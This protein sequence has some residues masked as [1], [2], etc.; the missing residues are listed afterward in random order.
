MALSKEAELRVRAIL[1]EDT[2]ADASVIEQILCRRGHEVVIAQNGRE[3]VEKC[4]RRRF[5]VILMDVQMPG[6]D[7]L[8]AAAA[9]RALA[10]PPNDSSTPPDV[11]II[12]VTAYAIEGVKDLCLEAGMNAFVPKPVDAEEVLHL[13]E[14][15]ART[16][17][18]TVFPSDDVR[19]HR[20]VSEPTRRTGLVHQESPPVPLVGE[21]ILDLQ[22]T[23]KRLGEDEALLDSLIAMFVDDAPA[24][25]ERIE[26]G[27]DDP[28]PSEPTRAAHSLKGLAANLSARIA[29]ASAAEVEKALA[30]RNRDEARR[31]LE[32]LRRRIDEV[33]AELRRRR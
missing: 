5:D 19:I 7:G 2:P 28:D 9:I 12:A 13:V 33:I 11:P 31:R 23:L 8:E 17:R 22:A 16:H 14:L 27:L 24:M 29:V 1:A 18:K 6:M 4:R 20:P 26:T 15:H 10:P 21:G 25:V 32:V 30:R 3:M